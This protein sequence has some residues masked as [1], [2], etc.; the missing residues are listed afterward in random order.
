[1]SHTL[2]LGLSGVVALKNAVKVDVLLLV[3][4]LDE[5]HH[6][7][8][9]LLL[10]PGP[11]LIVPDMIVEVIEPVSGVRVLSALGTARHQSQLTGVT[12]VGFLQVLACERQLEDVDGL[13]YHVLQL[14]DL[15]FGH[16]VRIA[17][18]SYLF[19]EADSKVIDKVLGNST[20]ESPTSIPWLFL[21]ESGQ[22]I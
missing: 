9:T 16:S 22:A 4:V 2:C 19:F 10:K 13:V 21:Q 15:F 18:D 11:T 20:T 12:L 17:I 7:A 8:L 1:M 14:F 5:C 3:Q 6:F